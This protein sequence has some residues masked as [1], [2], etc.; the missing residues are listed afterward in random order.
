[1]RVDDIKQLTTYARSCGK[2]QVY[3]AAG[4]EFVPGRG[5]K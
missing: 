3:N 2:A 1:M 5:T 4:I